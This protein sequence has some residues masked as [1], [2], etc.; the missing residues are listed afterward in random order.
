MSLVGRRRPKTQ[1][2]A[3]LQ[4]WVL[5]NIELVKAQDIPCW[6]SGNKSHPQESVQAS[7]HQVGTP[8]LGCWNTGRWWWGH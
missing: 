2:Q 4:R 7:D 1:N 5:V 8:G 6:D 3:G